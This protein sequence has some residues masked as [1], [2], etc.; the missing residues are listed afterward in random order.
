MASTSLPGHW[1]D[2]VEGDARPPAQADVV[3]I[4]GGIAGV[5]A[6][7]TLAKSGQ[8][9]ALLEKGI[10]GGEQSSR[11]WGWCRLMSRDEREIPLMQRAHAL[12]DQ[13][14][15]ETGA[16]MGF[17]RNGLVYL[18]RSE[19]ELA[20]WQAWLDMAR[21]YQVPV[22]IIDADEARRIAPGTP[23]DWI[24]G[25]VSPQDGRAEPG[26]AAPAIARGARAAGA[27]VVQN[28]AVRG[29]DTTGGRIS[30]VFTEHGLVRTGTVILAGGAWS[31]M[32]LRRH[33][34]ALPQASVHSTVFATTPAPQVTPGGGGF[35]SEDYCLTPL[36]DGG[37][38]VAA[39]ARTRLEVTPA[40]IRYARQFWKSL[41]AN[42]KLVDLRFGRSFVEGPDTLHGKWRFDRETVFER[43][44][45]LDATPNAAIVE[46]ALREIVAACPALAGIQAARL[47]AGW[48]DLT[49]DVVPVID[50]VAAIPG[51]VVATGLSGHGFGIGPAIGELAGHIA[52][53]AT[54]RVDP[55]P[56]RL[57]RFD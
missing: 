23:Q 34:I 19:K 41:L 7:Y 15:A 47:W 24:G 2:P 17:R 6:A 20:G 45:V 51:L 39:K 29:L 37:Y 1:V 31:S 36:L 55:A 33:G 52:T 49:P 50:H 12:W 54:P 42:R 57:A 18:T 53:A 13:W 28:C 35:Y 44:R 8:S 48:I 16:D 10:V 56:F 9:V 5:S 30:G 40:G 43:I 25:V 38:I 3:I 11:N 27:A 4:G 32:F 21:P 26:L 14:P 46:P 22:R